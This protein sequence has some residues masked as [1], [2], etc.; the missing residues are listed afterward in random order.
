MLI[1]ST[2]KP[3]YRIQIPQEQRKTYKHIL[4][5]TTEDWRLRGKVF[6]PVVAINKALCN[7]VQQGATPCLSCLLVNSRFSTFR[8]V[9]FE[10]LVQFHNI[11]AQKAGSLQVLIVIALSCAY[12]PWVARFFHSTVSCGLVNSGLPEW[13]QNEP[14][15]LLKS[16]VF[17]QMLVFT[18]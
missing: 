6:A 15:I 13:T 12:A 7:S 1:T 2:L 10:A 18:I 14:P 17:I 16:A 8:V 3:C 4:F 11:Q 5:I 9:C